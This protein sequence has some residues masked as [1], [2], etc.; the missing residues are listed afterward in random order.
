MFRSVLVRA[1]VAASVCLVVLPAAASA[2]PGARV[3]ASK[4]KMIKAVKY[5]GVQHLHFSY[6]PIDIL[7]G[8]NNIEALLNRM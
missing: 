4:D 5:P 3:S 1:A 8:Q 6:G 7:P 2:L